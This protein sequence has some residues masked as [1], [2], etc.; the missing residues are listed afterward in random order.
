MTTIDPNYQRRRDR[1]CS[2]CGE[3]G[4]LGDSRWTRCSYC[5]WKG[6]FENLKP[7]GPVLDQLSSARE[8]L[9]NADGA[10]TKAQAVSSAYESSFT[11]KRPWWKKLLAIHED[12]RLHELREKVS[13]SQ[14]TL[15]DASRRVEQLQREIRWK[16]RRAREVRE[17][18]ARYRVAREKLLERRSEG[19]RTREALLEASLSASGYDRA[20]LRIRSKDYKRGNPLENTI[21]GPWFLRVSEVFG[22][23]CFSCGNESDL[24]L[25]HYAIPKNE[26]GNFILYNQD[27]GVLR[28]NLV[29]LC[30]PCNS[31]KGENRALSFFSDEE[32]QRLAKVHAEILRMLMQDRE[33]RKVLVRWYDVPTRSLPVE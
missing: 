26:G 30:R 2:E 27:E 21:K 9:A 11:A 7:V 18:F 12:R 4:L 32:H 8:E 23:R 16:Q 13:N 3:E 25:D 29:L 20:R 1:R 5:Y 14:Q 6:Q 31:A 10:L 17:N 33:A 22:G 28:V 24:T 19:Q 15:S